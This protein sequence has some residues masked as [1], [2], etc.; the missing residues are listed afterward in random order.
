MR[1]FMN[2][3]L[4]WLTI[5]LRARRVGS[6]VEIDDFIS[7]HRCKSCKRA[8]DTVS[9]GPR[10]AWRRRSYRV[11]V[12]GCRRCGRKRTF[13]FDITEPLGQINQSAMVNHSR[14]ERFEPVET[15]PTSSEQPVLGFPPSHNPDTRFADVLELVDR[16]HRKGNHDQALNI[17]ESKPA[18]AC[19]D[20]WIWKAALLGWLRRVDEQE[21]CFE[22]AL[23]RPD[24]ANTDARVARDFATLLFRQE[25]YSEVLAVTTDG[26]AASDLSC[27]CYYFRAQIALGKASDFLFKIEK[28]AESSGSDPDAWLVYLEALLAVDDRQR[29]NRVLSRLENMK[30]SGVVFDSLQE[31]YLEQLQS[32]LCDH[33]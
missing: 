9:E 3:V 5:P 10:A 32:R 2:R 12:A 24:I 23:S 18:P 30:R 33:Y 19:G 27:H 11:A 14:T 20:Y 28:L 21:A 8:L 17:L 16:L 4:A 1:L 29:A 31:E 13:V 26:I 22:E 15:K 25:R 7:R 6:L